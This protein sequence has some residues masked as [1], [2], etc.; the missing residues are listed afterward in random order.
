M[1]HLQE[2]V[3]HGQ[4][5][6]KVT[7]SER[8]PHF[9]TAPCT[10]NISYRVEAKSDFYLIY[11]HVNG[12]LHLQCQRCL[13]EFD[14]TY[15]NDTVIAVCCSDERAEELLELYECIASP[16]FQVRLEDLI[17]DELHLYALQF[18]PEITDCSSEIN[19]F[20]TRKNNSY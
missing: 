2:L 9:V 19:Q 13:E 16:H 11:L 4:Q 1:L 20:L 14:Y 7:L 12:L 6:Q 15:D 17:I 18:H 5:S 10:L 3:K 8:L